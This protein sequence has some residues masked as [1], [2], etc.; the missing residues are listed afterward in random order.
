[1][2]KLELIERVE[3]L[4]RNVNQALKDITTTEDVTRKEIIEVTECYINSD[5]E[6]EINVCWHCADIIENDELLSKLRD[7]E[8][9][10]DEVETKLD[11]LRRIK[12]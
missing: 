9:S 6:K 12:K 3:Q 1:M 2:T 11:A 8:I 4:R 7:I 5:T 10:Y